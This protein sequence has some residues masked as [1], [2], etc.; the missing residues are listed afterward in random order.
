MLGKL[1]STM[2][3]GRKKKENTSRK[4]NRLRFEYDPLPHS[5]THIRLVQINRQPQNGNISCDLIAV[6]LAKAPAYRALSYTWGNESVQHQ[7]LLN[8]RTFTVAKNLYDFLCAE[9][10]RSDEVKPF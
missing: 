5:A 2:L 9:S 1:Q 4:T 6:P 8:Q 7:I 10:H 3:M